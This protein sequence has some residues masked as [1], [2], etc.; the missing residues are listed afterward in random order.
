M[1]N[2]CIFWGVPLDIISN[3]LPTQSIK[4]EFKFIESRPNPDRRIIQEVQKC[5]SYNY[6]KIVYKPRQNF[7]MLSSQRASQNVTSSIQRTV[8]GPPQLL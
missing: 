7:F 6:K 4:F 5:V 8:L 1:Y 2:V 3:L